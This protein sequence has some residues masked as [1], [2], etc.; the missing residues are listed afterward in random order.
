MAIIS[1][2]KTN[3]TLKRYVLISLIFALT[4]ISSNAGADVVVLKTGKKFEVEKVWREN[5]RVWIIFHGMRASI[6]ENKVARIERKTGGDARKS[7]PQKEVSAGQKDVT[8]PTHPDSLSRKAKNVSQTAFPA[9][10]AVIRED[11]DSIFPDKTYSKL[12]WG[13]RFA[14]I[15]GLVKINDAEGPDDVVEYERANEN[16]KLGRAT[17]DSIHYSFWRDKLYMLTIRTRGRSNYTALRDDI[18]RQFGKERRDDQADERYLWTK[19][20]NDIML[21][22]SKEGEQG[23]LWLRSSKI[24]RQYKLARMNGHASYL[25]WMK[26]RN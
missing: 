3:L 18:L 13:T 9:Q 17:L 15:S 6:P 14:A 12:K 24:D 2:L 23:L 4:L 19:A 7:N 21:Q 1:C 22:Y 25:R 5:D 10:P 26:S 11:S 8:R 20:P 16:L